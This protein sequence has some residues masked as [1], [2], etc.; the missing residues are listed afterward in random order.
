MTLVE[1]LCRQADRY[2]DKVAFRF[3]YTKRHAWGVGCFHSV[4]CGA[5]FY[6]WASCRACQMLG[7]NRPR[8]G[9]DTSGAFTIATSPG[10]LAVRSRLMLCARTSSGA[11]TA[12]VRA[13]QPRADRITAGDEVGVGSRSHGVEYGGLR[14][15]GDTMPLLS[16]YDI[17]AEVSPSALKR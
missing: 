4:D 13:V 17:A 16:C 11:S 7:Y 12:A 3:S 15:S 10:R 9:P 14:S 6:G 2:G 8:S 1:L 5:G